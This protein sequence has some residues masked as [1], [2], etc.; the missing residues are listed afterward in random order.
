[1]SLKE[2]V[3]FVKNEL[4]SEEKFLESFVKL[5]RF[6]KKYKILLIIL[7]VVIIA[8]FI[9]FNVKNYFDNQNKIKANIA[10]EKVLKNFNDKNAFKTLEESNKKLY[11]V[12][13]YLK[14]KDEGKTANVDVMFFD[15]LSKYKKALEDKNLSELNEV[16][17]QRDFLLKE[18][19][20]FNK[21]LLEAT[22]GKYNDA[23][24]T[25]KLI[26]KESKVNELVKIL[27]HYLLTK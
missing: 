11:Q 21:A 20:L 1:M 26:P 13:L 25:L 24:A 3:D 4:D 12:A 6:Y 19:A 2:N 8:T 18:F 22:N 27:N 23:K 7:L 17:M 9:G 5:E 14:A 15:S 10:F 16:S